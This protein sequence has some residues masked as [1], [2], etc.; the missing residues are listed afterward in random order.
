[1]I[2]IISST[3]SLDMQKAYKI[4]EATEPVF[5]AEAMELAEL[6]KNYSQEELM[7]LMKI[8]EKL[9][10][11]NYDRYMNFHKEEVVSKEALF[12]FSGDVYKA[13]NPFD[14]SEEHVE[15]AQ[16]HLRILSGLYGVLKPL[17]KI[18]EYRLEMATKVENANNKDL[19]SFWTEKITNNILKEVSGQER[20]AILN[21]ASL[22]YSKTL[23]RAKL[24]DIE[25]F[26]VEF[27]ENRN[28]QFKIVG[29]YAKKARGTMVSYIIKNKIDSI[30]DVKKF[31]EDGY[32]FNEEV[33]TENNIVFT[34]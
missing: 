24:K 19:Y 12:S 16:N 8:S 34:R 20:K 23:D 26:D 21:L 4:N 22:E 9:A 27:K 33:S 17:D 1:M 13:M 10:E 15:F 7:K 2:T 14:Y 6:L 32:V 31:K 30:E 3:K 28:G 11:V 18:K 29:T 25:I 5:L